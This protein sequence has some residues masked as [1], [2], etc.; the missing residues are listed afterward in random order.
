MLKNM[1]LAVKIALLVFVSLTV[2]L[3]AS[4]FQIYCKTREAV[5]AETVSASRQI[6]LT[7]GHSM[8]TFGKTGDMNDLELFLKT[9]PYRK[10]TEKIGVAI[11]D[12]LNR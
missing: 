1:S 3:G 8:Q 6:A 10:D 2:I 5:D 4:S 12:K 7:I 11:R 9:A